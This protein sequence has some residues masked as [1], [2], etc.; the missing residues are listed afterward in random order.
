MQVDVFALGTMMF[1]VFSSVITS[2]VVLGPT[3]HVKAAEL[4]ALKVRGQRS[5]R[6]LWQGRPCSWD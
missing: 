5:A 6:T 1:E 4:Y 2:V 3:L